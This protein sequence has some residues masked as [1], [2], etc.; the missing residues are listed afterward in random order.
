MHSHL[1]W[2][3]GLEKPAALLQPI[4]ALFVMASIAHTGTLTASTVLFL[5]KPYQLASFNKK[6]NPMWEFTAPGEKITDWTTL[7][8]VIDRPDAK[9]RPELDRLAEGVIA[10][11]K[12]NGGKI[13]LAKTMKD[14]SGI[15]YN[16]IVAAFDEP[17]KHRFELNFVK[18]GLGRKNAYMIVYG[19]RVTDPADYPGKAKIF[20]D[21]RS[22][23]IGKAL[24]GTPL[25]DLATLPRN[26]F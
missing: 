7:L 19:V 13:L 24:A 10:Q 9:S 18:V 2:I 16:Y 25:P 14:P 4:V 21:Q 17:A 23:E 12:S 22:S 5:S 1:D 6:R 26:E 11:Y 20:L 3:P 15:P 8:T